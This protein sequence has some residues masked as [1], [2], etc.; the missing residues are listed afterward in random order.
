MPLNCLR[1]AGAVKDRLLAGPKSIFIDITTA[2]NINCGFCWI[3]SPLLKK[4]PYRKHIN[5]GFKT[6]KDTVDAARE[7][8]SEEISLAGDGEPTI[9]PQIKEIIGY[10]KNKGL[11]LYLATNATFGTALMPSI[12]KVDHL[13]VNLCSPDK[14][15]Y[16]K[17]QAPNNGHLHDKLSENLKILCRL[18]KKYGKPHINIAFII[19]KHNYVLIPKMLEYC[20]RLGVSEMTF[21]IV[22]TTKDTRALALWPSDKIRLR[23][24]TSK[25]G[26]KKFDFCHN[27]GDVG[28]ALDDYASSSF[29]MTRCF[30]GWFNLLVD[31][32]KNIGIC[33]HNENLI[34][35]NLAKNSIRDI[36]GGRQAQRLRLLCKYG[37]D[38][39]K[40]PFRNECEW[41]HWSKENSKINAEFEKFSGIGHR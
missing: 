4:K 10:I 21:R 24:I 35:G 1:L 39:G 27:L 17:L 31:F 9:H 33:C 41:C 37:F 18:K 3:H 28:E 40:Y 16:R 32:N 36:W 5:L 12:A 20:S 25:F 6:I 38:L 8:R 2:C 30:S 15:N 11:K 13:Y 7:W 14:D 29:N 26:K 34:A 22:E 23:N 19:T